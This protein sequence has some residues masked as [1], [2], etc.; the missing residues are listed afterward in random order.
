MEARWIWSRTIPLLAAALLVATCQREE[1][2]T[3]PP[4]AETEAAVI[5]ALA[6]LSPGGSDPQVAASTKGAT[7]EN[8]AY[9]MSQ[10]K[11]L[12]QWFNC[13]GCHGNGGGGSGPALMDDKWIYGSGI[14][15]IVATIREGRPNG[16]PSFRGRIP[17]D[18]IWQIAAYVRSLGGFA[19]KDAAPSRD[20]GMQSRPAEN[21]LPAADPHAAGVPQ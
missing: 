19:P 18:E 12:F 7:Y 13:S 21:R 11:R 3:D 15:N 14:D 6:P 4:K 1:R 17:D 5:V 9:A 8:N 16:M 20:D 10:G 2:D